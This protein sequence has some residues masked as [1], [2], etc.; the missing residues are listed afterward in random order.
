[1]K[2]RALYLL[3]CLGFFLLL[4]LCNGQTSA[5]QPLLRHYTVRDGLPSNVIYD[6]C[7]DTKGFIWFCTDQGV[8]RYD[9]HRFENYSAKDG[10]PDNEIFS[11]REDNDHRFWLVCYNHK[12]CYLLEGHIYNSNNDA[13]CR[14]IEAFGV[15]YIEMYRDAAGKACLAGKRI[16]SLSGNIATIIP[17]QTELTGSLFQHF[18]HN[19]SDYILDG[20]FLYG[21][22][23][24]CTTKL[25]SGHFSCVYQNG[26]NVFLTD[27]DTRLNL[28]DLTLTK[29]NLKINKKVTS[30]FWI[31]AITSLPGDSSILCCTEKGVKIYSRRSGKFLSSNVLPDNIACNRTLKDKEGNHWFTTL[32][33]GCYMLFAATP[34]IYNEQTKL[35]NEEVLFISNGTDNKILAGCD[36]GFFSIIDGSKVQNNSLPNYGYRNRIKFIYELKSHEYI[37]GSDGGLYRINKAGDR[38]KTIYRDAMKDA[39]V[40]DGHCV[41]A[42]ATGVFDYNIATGAI[43]NLWRSRTTAIA[44]GKDSTLWFGILNGLYCNR[45][46][47][48][49][50]FDKDACLSD[51]RITSL[52]IAPNGVLS[53]A[54]NKD[55]IFIWNGLCMLHL[56]LASGISSNNCRRIVADSA[57]NI[58]LCTDNGID[59]INIQHLPSYLIDHYSMAD[60]LATNKINDITVNGH[61]LYAATQEGIIV[62]STVTHHAVIKQPDLYITLVST[63]GR[64]LNN[65]GAHMLSYNQND[66]QIN[67]TG[68]SFT[69]GSE[70]QYKYL[71]AGGG[72][73]TIYTLLNAV[74]L[75]ALRPGKYSFMVWA[76]VASGLWTA[77]PATFSFTIRPPFWLTFWF[78]ALMCLALCSLFYIFYRYQLNIL[79]DKASKQA[80]RKRKM[81]ELELQAVRAQINPHFLFNAL[82]SIQ[83]YYSQHDERK[84]NQYLTSFAQFMRKTLNFSQEPWISLKDELGMLETYISLEQMRFKNTFTYK[85]IA[86]NGPDWEHIKIPSM[87]IQPYVENAINH[88]LR[89]LPEHTGILYITFRLEENVLICIIDDNG[90]GFEEAGKR[91]PKEHQSKGMHINRQRIETINQLYNTAITARI[92]DKKASGSNGTLIELFIPQNI[93]YE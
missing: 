47:K 18:S 15:E 72:N 9:G 54:T 52:S 14:Q 10:L 43:Y 32:N 28:Y 22:K 29:D 83:N 61:K 53:I 65:A 3:Q 56:N 70:V 26:P 67:F 63:K 77:S 38:I 33:K 68:I 12:P 16:C 46:G 34:Y 64:A 58:W 85:L 73:D 37:A 76:R 36:K 41:V 25:L 20:L 71:V 45:K 23:N 30:P 86:G 7:Q 89:S 74:N 48:T 91:R 55:G 24:G 88:G 1:M 2:A 35:K 49:S 44:L 5:Q 11:I 4:L 57:G 90:I 8:C 84:G 40:V 60:G 69:S 13:L 27:N 62:L 75:S 78:I 92:N 93:I 31:Y 50:R 82:N 87:L 59:K 17:V 81:A 39:F 21:I 6:I 19:G 80:V 42:G 51:C 79:K 66:L